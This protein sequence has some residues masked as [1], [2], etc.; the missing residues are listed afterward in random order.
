MYP[1]FLAAADLH[2]YSYDPF[3]L[4]RGF[5][6]QFHKTV[7]TLGWVH[8]PTAGWVIT[9]DTSQRWQIFMVASQTVTC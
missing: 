3:T 8:H 5:I 1:V 6:A 9:R 2:P 7:V 4:V